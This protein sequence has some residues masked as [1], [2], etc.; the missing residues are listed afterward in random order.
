MALIL[1]IESST[2]VCSVAIARDGVMI[3]SREN[4]TGQNHAKLVTVF[5]NELLT[6]LNL[7]VDQLDAVAVSGG[8]GSYTGL[9]IGVSVAK[10]LC[11]ASGLPLIAITSLE[12]MAYHVIHNRQIIYNTKADNV[13][14]CPM[15]DARRM[16]VY[17]AFYNI[18]G[19]QVRGIQADIIDHQSY[20]QFLENNTILFFGNGADKCREVIAHP[21]AVFINGII[22]SSENMIPLSERD[23]K[24]QKFVNVAYYEPFYLK[25]FVATV[26]V[27]NI[28][29]NG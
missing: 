5:I 11:Y 28:F 2:E 3:C 6:E 29:K 25:D 24:L 16:E 14:F 1:N 18:N 10:G 19:I 20:L 26:P 27:K 21:N 7:T 9:R 23:F 8:P 13:L 12:A 4:L 22:T 15:I 17:T